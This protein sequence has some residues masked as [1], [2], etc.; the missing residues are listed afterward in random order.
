MEKT[1]VAMLRSDADVAAAA[2]GGVHAVVAPSSAVLPYAV[3]QRVSTEHLAGMDGAVGTIE[4]RLRIDAC[5]AS[6][7]G[8][9]ALADVIRER[10]HG[11]RQTFADG[12]GSCDL[13][14]ESDEYDAPN[15][16][17]EEGVFRRVQEY[18][19]WMT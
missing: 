6:Y 19:L 1:V 12:R 16:A 13:M 15:D 8:A 9:I 18:R 11:L 14:D 10:L 17:S 5:A 7:A 2:T 3:F 4:A